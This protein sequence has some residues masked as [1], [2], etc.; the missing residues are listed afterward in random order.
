LSLF[1]I[2]QNYNSVSAIKNWLGNDDQYELVK[3]ADG[4]SHPGSDTMA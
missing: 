4:G 3:M 1:F 2:L